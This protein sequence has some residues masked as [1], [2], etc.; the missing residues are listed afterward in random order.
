MTDARALFRD[1]AFAVSLV[2][3]VVV[4]LGFG[5]VVPVLPLFVRAFDVG[6]FAVSGVVAAFSGVRLLS[7]IYTGGL[8]DRI[9]GRRAVGYGAIIV[10]ISSAGVAVAPNYWTVLVV[11]GIGGF[12]SA[13]FFNA[14]MTHV[15][16]II[17][18]DVRGRAVGALQGAFLFGIAFGPS[19][20]GVLAEPL[21]LRWPFVIYA[22]FCGSAGLVALRFQRG[23]EASNQPQPPVLEPEDFAEAGPA[24]PKPHGLG[25][26][27]RLTREFC[28]DRAFVAALVMMAASRWAAT[29]VRFSLVS[30]FGIEVVGT[31][32]AVVGA[33]LTL[34]V[35]TQLLVLWPTGRIADTVGRRVIAAPAY[36]LFAVF[37]GGLAF[38]TTVPLFLVAMA[39]YGVGTGLTSVTPPAVVADIVPTEQTGV[40]VGVLNTA[41]DL[42]S[43]LGPL[44]SGWLAQAYGYGW[45]FGASAALLAVGGLVALTMRET[46]PSRQPAAARTPT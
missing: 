46:L 2:I 1:P 26:T 40:A 45:G 10:A 27:L 17:P 6:L 30:V 39:L 5:L 15:V 23:G 13:L 3:A 22:A 42:G 7:S 38:A 35:G 25:R 4:A 24:N 43:V 11:R 12:G 8:A 16:R 21:G 28:T 36:L 9:G 32:E 34:A 18:P 41:G 20:G 37:A 29:G 14:L 19:V 44:V 31:T 33:A